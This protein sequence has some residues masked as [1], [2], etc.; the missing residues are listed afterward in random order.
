[1]VNEAVGIKIKF[2][3]KGYILPS[4]YSIDKGKLDHCRKQKY[5]AA[6]KP[7]FARFYI[8]DLWQRIFDFR[9]ECHECQDSICP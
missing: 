8:R 7:N 1:M 5:C 9:C 4:I 3:R 6:Q 2:Q